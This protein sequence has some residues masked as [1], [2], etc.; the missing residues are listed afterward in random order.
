MT[1]EQSETLRETGLEAI[2]C[3]RQDSDGEKRR[4]A[5][6]LFLRELL[7]LVSCAA[8][9]TSLPDGD[10]CAQAERCQ[11]AGFLPFPA[12]EMIRALMDPEM[13]ADDA[14]R[15]ALQDLI[16]GLCTWCREA[17][18]LAPDAGDE[19]QAEGKRRA[20][21]AADRMAFSG[22][23]LY[24]VV[25]GRL[26]LQPDNMPCVHYVMQQHGLTPVRQVVLENRSGF[27]LQEVALCMHA[28]PAFCQPVR[29]T[30]DILG[31]GRT[32]RI[33]DIQLQMDGEWLSQ[34]T[35]KVKAT[36]H[37]TLEKDG[38]I[39][40]AQ[41][42]DM[43]VLPFDEWQGICVEPALLCSF[44][45]PNHPAIA[46]LLQKAAGML[47]M[48]TGDPSLN[49]YQTRDP[50][51]VLQQAGAIYAAIQAEG[52]VYAVHPASFERMGQR[53]RLCDAVLGQKLGNCLDLTVLYCA[54]LEAAG[55]HPLIV[56][57]QEHAYAGVWLEDKSFPE[58]VQDDATLVT[59]RLADGVNEIAVVECTA[60]TGGK[61]V[62]FDEAR[63]TAE[64]HFRSGTSFECVIDVHRARLSGVVPM[65]LRVERDG[66]W[67]VE[68]PAREMEAPRVPES[69]VGKVDVDGEQTG[70]DSE[71]SARRTQWERR[72]LDLGLRNSLISMRLTR[73]V[74]PLMVPSLHDLEDQL[75]EGKEFSLLPRPE[76][77]ALPEGGIQIENLHLIGTQSAVPGSEFHN[78]RLRSVYAEGE[79]GRVLREI[80][81]AA[82]TAMEENG[83]NALY[84]S[85]GLLK[86]YETPRSQKPRFA[87]IVLLPVEVV[88]RSVTQGYTLR[89]RDDEI[90]VNVTMLE[91]LKQ[92][93][94]LTIT[95]LDP[96]PQDDRNVDLLRVFTIL[97]Q[98]IMEE[99][100]WDVLECA[101][102]GI[103]SFSQF[104]MWNDLRNR[105]QDLMKSPVVR[106]LMEKRL[107]WQ[108]EPMEMA[109]R[110][111]E[112]DV[113][114]PTQVDA[115][116]LFAVKAA[117]KGES[118][119]LHGPPGTGKS[120]TI[121][122]MIANALGKGRTVLFV[123][124]KMAA[125]E[126]V[127]RRLEE[128]G[129]GPFCLELHSNKS[130][131]KD[132]L[133][134]LRMAAEVTKGTGPEEFERRAEQLAEMRSQL[135]EYAAALHE[136][137]ENGYSLFDAVNA[138]EE[139]R[140][141]PDMEE[142]GEEFARK[143]SRPAMEQLAQ[144]IRQMV[145]A[146]QNLG[147]PHTHSLARVL[148]EEY[149]QHIRREAGIRAKDYLDAVLALG[150]AMDPLA[151]LFS[152]EE[153][154]GMEEISRLED[155]CR[156]LLLW[157]DF[158]KS[159]SGAEDPTD[160]LSD[161]QA[162]AGR[163]IEL[164]KVAE[165]LQRRWKPSF[166][167][168]RLED[169]QK[170]LEAWDENQKKWLLPR[171]MGDGRL[172][173]T[174]ASHALGKIQKET[175]REDLEVLIRYLK[176]RQDADSEQERLAADLEGLRLDSREAWQ[177][178][179]ASARL[180]GESLER[181][182]GIR[183][184]SMVRRAHGGDRSLVP[185][186]QAFL[187]AS[188]R[189]REK[190]EELY[191]L[192]GVEAWRGPD[193]TQAEETLCRAILAG[194]GEL[195]DVMHFNAAAGEV[196]RGGIP[197]ASRA[198]RDGMA[199]EDVLLSFRKAAFRA[200]AEEGMERHPVLSRFSGQLFE[201]KLEEYRRLERESTRLAREEIY[202]RLASSVPNFVREAAQSS[203]VGILQRAIRSG[204]RGISIRRLFEQIPTLLTRLCPCMLMSPISVAQYLDPN[205]MPFDLVVFDE[206]S[207]LP[208]CKAVGALAR[209][210]HAVIVGDPNQMPPTSFF[211]TTANLT[212]DDAEAEDLE[213]ILDDCLAISMPQTHLLWHYRS[214]HES[215]IAFSN[216]QFYDGRLY[217]FPSVNDR[218]R[219][220]H[221]RH[222]DGVFTRGGSRQNRREAEEVVEEIR[223]RCHSPRE[224]ERSVG[225]VTF[226]ISQQ[227]L[228]DDLL[229]D[230]CAADPQLD[231]WV[232]GGDEP[233]FIKNLENVQGDE[234]DVILFSVGYGPDEKGR[235]TMNFGPLNRDGGWR[236]LN[237]AVTRARQE[238]LVF[239][240][241]RPEQIAQSSARGVRALQAFLQYAGGQE[242]PQSEAEMR[243]SSVSRQ[244]IARSIGRMLSAH[245][246]LVD[247]QVGRSAFR[248]DLGVRDPEKEDAYLLGILL[249]GEAY[250]SARTTRDREI[251]Q[252]S[253]LESLGWRILRVWTVDWWEQPDRVQEQI[254]QEVEK[255][256]KAEVPS[257]P[258]KA[259]M[260]TEGPEEHRVDA[261]MSA[262]VHEELRESDD[263]KENND[264]IPVY[265]PAGIQRAALSVDQLVSGKCDVEI[266][267]T[268]RE[269][270][271]L[272]API[273]E[274]LLSR[275]VIQCYG[276]SRSSARIQAYLSHLMDREGFYV[277]QS[278][279][280]RVF[281]YNEQM[282]RT[283]AGFRRSGEGN[284]RRE[285]KDVPCEEAAN[286][287]CLVL[288]DAVSMPEEDLVREGARLL[289]YSRTGSAVAQLMTE[290]IAYA[291]R[292]Q[293]ICQNVLGQWIL[294]PESQ[295]R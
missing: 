57:E 63:H 91:K 188:G 18:S 145:V 19:L 117:E 202:C 87:P 135:D 190:Q 247:E 231:A 31:N 142:M 42:T 54:L 132:V 252:V 270:V 254:L 67:T 66:R 43:E 187:Q 71:E 7:R 245:G 123:A 130:R 69:V 242:L 264:E 285:A 151:E 266:R 82:R 48:W 24:A 129:I 292:R 154:R 111:D 164:Q 134:Q 222:V 9:S 84:L 268:I 218:S 85:L 223:R 158:P 11:E 185:A 73:T 287:L 203:E 6:R 272:E 37:W 196:T 244:G 168:R 76:D 181:M 236:R 166:L 201:Q 251:G 127:Q 212:E 278:G 232:Y 273:C 49:A 205:H 103:F 143:T 159:W 221:L 100:R 78:R 261:Q 216:S 195:R 175:L 225:V 138:Y 40:A 93:F 146:G 52:I 230:A 86:W 284:A 28:S 289:G 155:L 176:D 29:H 101:S 112:G 147:H 36:L 215:L 253:V 279:G 276:L 267:G 119:V 238:M 21:E 182:D 3:L 109:E 35:E 59:K 206:A 30:V 125:L 162:L 34:M 259:S 163:E 277:T 141:A 258:E 120:Q 204:G 25:R 96:L 74:L 269:I 191:S 180:A 167:T 172:L 14:C 77:I 208:T 88:R 131:K 282:Q 219:R 98:A 106:S 8:G 136:P 165:E 62:S 246:Y 160:L 32:L 81:R 177:N 20:A 293:L 33:Q 114:V 243:R 224:A 171:V 271:A 89:L 102:L 152:V 22:D 99:K 53:I 233:V 122:A 110:V 128:I 90:Q 234:R 97:R 75:G 235:V 198:Y 161:I 237:V 286:A 83:A 60:A 183:D 133:E 174:L 241:L 226:N 199:G 92:D 248:V 280:G 263:R 170:D 45:M 169:V 140:F 250:A 126:V 5:V 256:R 27:A 65:P 217:T 95:G 283:Y 295:D 184:A 211:T 94:K 1:W 72:L 173:R 265:Q 281:W 240:T 209:G 229:S 186:M 179:L 156:E 16:Q 290:G 118:F 46:P 288:R 220:V 148:G 153:T 210:E 150:G 213:S 275:R 13:V 200:L 115:S 26:S 107:T 64:A 61:Q 249:D 4:E 227:N 262:L 121:T 105:T 17:F 294:A 207:Q 157:T 214:R 139:V 239:S 50:N 2:A 79:H 80:Y 274:G 104:V 68:V 116:Q 56:V 41:E 144:A 255:A 137:M 108:A 23:A 189:M 58:S 55:L 149:T 228:I 260:E 178:V 47:E 15:G 194:E 70:G 192:L 10:L 12:D 197:Q 38:Q 44:V 193:W 257:V 291:A 124:E 113:L 51:R 39:L